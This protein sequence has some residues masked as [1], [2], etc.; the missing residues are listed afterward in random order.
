MNKKTMDPIAKEM[1]NRLITETAREIK[2]K[3]SYFAECYPSIFNEKCNQRVFEGVEEYFV[4]DMKILQPYPNI[5]MRG[6]KGLPFFYGDI[7]YRLFESEYTFAVLERVLE[8]MGINTERV[9]ELIAN[10]KFICS[11]LKIVEK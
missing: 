8:K 9:H 7:T 5:R 6:I 1:V 11:Y 10:G 3:M 4:M 2:G